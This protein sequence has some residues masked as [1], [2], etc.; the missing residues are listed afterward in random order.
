MPALLGTMLKARRSFILNTALKFHALMF[1]HQH[2][3]HPNCIKLHDAF[4]DAE[5]PNLY[6]VLTY[7]EGGELLTMLQEHIGTG[8]YAILSLLWPWHMERGHAD[9]CSRF[10]RGQGTTKSL[11]PNSA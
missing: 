2:V 4:E 10:N 5:G 3:D 11:G 6:L 8:R 7:V 9:W 1:S